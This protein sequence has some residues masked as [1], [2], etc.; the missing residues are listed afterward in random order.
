MKRRYK[1]T[2]EPTIFTSELVGSLKESINYT[3][4]ISS[5][6]QGGS[7]CAIR[8]LR[9]DTKGK[10]ENCVCGGAGARERY[11][12]LQLCRAIV[13]TC[14]SNTRRWPL[15]WSSV[16]ANFLSRIIWESFVSTRSSG[17]AIKAATWDSSTY[18]AATRARTIDV[19]TSQIMC[20]LIYVIIWRKMR[21]KGSQLPW[22]KA[23]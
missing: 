1:K 16:P 17:R 8:L 23:R 11:S 21:G 14:F 9:Y 19:A 2:A 12:T 13:H 22:R 3:A 20:A 7:V 15:P 10:C 18:N 4:Q 5:C 6:C